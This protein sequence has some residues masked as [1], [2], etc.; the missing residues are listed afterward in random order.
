MSTV[1]ES[2][3]VPTIAERDAELM[4]AR[5]AAIHVE[6]PAAVAALPPGIALA[7]PW[8]RIGAV[9]LNGV[10][11]TATLGIGWMIWAVILWQQGQNPGQRMLGLRVIDDTTKRVPT[12]GLMVVRN[13]LLYGILMPVLA[14]FVLPIALFFMPLWDDKKQSLWDKMTHTVVVSDP[15]RILEPL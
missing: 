15:E 13:F 9:L 6:G 2:D 1:S 12:Q 4:A 14:L 5:P 11:S 10:L 8:R 7:S 3:H